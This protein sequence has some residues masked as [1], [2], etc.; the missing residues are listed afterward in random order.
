V[1]DVMDRFDGADHLYTDYL[2]KDAI[3]TG[4]N[5]SDDATLE[6]DDDGCRMPDT[7]GVGIRCS[8]LR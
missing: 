6:T 4:V 1:G 3:N 7:E 5:L 8:K 2:C